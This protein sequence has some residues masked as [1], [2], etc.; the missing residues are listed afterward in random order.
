MYCYTLFH[1]LLKNTTFSCSGVPHCLF[2]RPYR[3]RWGFFIPCA[4]ELLQNP[5]K[6]ELFCISQQH[7]WTMVHNQLFFF[8]FVLQLLVKAPKFRAVLQADGITA[9]NC[10]CTRQP[11]NKSIC[12]Q[13]TYIN[14]GE[15][16][17][18]L[19]NPNQYILPFWGKLTKK[20]FLFTPTAWGR[21]Q[22]HRDGSCWSV[23]C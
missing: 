4:S 18:G 1:W 5:Q 21:Q 3:D 22:Q 11:L 6:C 23:S 17:S 19:Y 12:A 2:A 7:T 9:E 15:K 16:K 14:K 13:L 8:S 20:T 10:G